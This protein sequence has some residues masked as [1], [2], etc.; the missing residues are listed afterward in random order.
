MG[1]EIVST[2][3]TAIT[4]FATGVASTFVNVFDTIFVGAEGGLSN[5][6]IWGLVMGAIGVG[7]AL[8]RKFSN[9]AG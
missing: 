3:T 4:S 5:L 2:I 8:I 1:A 6:A 7:Y 9:K